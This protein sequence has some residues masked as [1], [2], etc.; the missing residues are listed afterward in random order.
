MRR[1]ISVLAAMLLVAAMVVVMAMPAFAGNG[2]AK[3]QNNTNPG[4]FNDSRGDFENNVCFDNGV[5][6]PQSEFFT[7]DNGKPQGSG[8]NEN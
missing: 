4:F 1:I 3:G 2:F 7:N 8:T 5:C 6:N